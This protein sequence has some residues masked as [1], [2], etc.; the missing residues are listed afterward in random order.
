MVDSGAWVPKESKWMGPQGKFD[1]KA[2][3]RLEFVP[4]A[5][6]MKGKLLFLDSIILSRIVSC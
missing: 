5:E 4:E 1:W 3:T 6:D 2:V